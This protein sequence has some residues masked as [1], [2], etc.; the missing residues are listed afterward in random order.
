MAADPAIAASFD[1]KVFYNHNVT[2]P[3]K[4]PIELVVPEN[5]EVANIEIKHLGKRIAFWEAATRQMDL[6]SA[7]GERIILFD[8]WA[9]GL[10]ES[11]VDWCGFKAP[12]N[13][14][15][16]TTFD[17]P[18]ALTVT[19]KDNTA[20]AAKIGDYITNSEKLPTES[21]QPQQRDKI[22]LL[23]RGA[24]SNYNALRKQMLGVQG[25]WNFGK[26]LVVEDGSK[27]AIAYLDGTS[28]TRY[29]HTPSGVQE[30][31]ATYQDGSN[32]C[33][34]DPLKVYVVYCSKAGEANFTAALE[35]GANFW[36][37]KVGQAFDANT[38]KSDHG[39]AVKPIAVPYNNFIAQISKEASATIEAEDFMGMN[40]SL[41]GGHGFSYL[42]DAEK[43]GDVN[44]RK[45]EKPDL[46]V[47]DGKTV[48]AMAQGEWLRFKV[49][50]VDAGDYVVEANVISAG[51][52]RKLSF[53]MDGLAMTDTAMVF[54]PNASGSTYAFVRL[55]QGEQVLSIKCD[56][57]GVS[58]DKITISRC[59]QDFRLLDASGNAIALSGTYNFGDLGCTTVQDLDIKNPGNVNLTLSGAPL[60]KITG[61]HA[62]EFEVVKFPTKTIFTTTWA[63][64]GSSKSAS[65]PAPSTLASAGRR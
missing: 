15:G 16:S 61:Q 7:S 62:S 18:I 33:I 4:P 37:D 38:F 50:V 19:L 27:K 65:T 24:G 31:S 17:S 42:D 8:K 35:L 59:S 56:T 10:G 20:K 45:G 1:W 64:A 48:V 54:V 57:T 25:D 49:N 40:T 43:W 26:M 53:Q 5:D 34:L 13:N 30:F 52:R 22:L 51:T 41:V 2:T 63:M 6:Y 44:L 21:A 36:D 29:D 28:L 11:L 55:R 58:L 9:P 32:I 14:I 39:P 12:W 47:M 23:N 46:E 3:G 60:V